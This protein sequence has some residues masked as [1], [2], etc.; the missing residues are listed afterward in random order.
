MAFLVPI[1]SAIAGAA[2]SAGLPISAGLAMAGAAA[3]V[4]F[5]A[6]AAF[7]YVLD[8]IMED[9]AVDTMSGRTLTRKD[10]TASRKIVYGTVRTGGTIVY[11]A[12]SSANNKY[13]HNVVVFSEGE[14]DEISE[15][16]FDDVK[17]MGLVSGQVR[18]YNKYSS[19]ADGSASAVG[20][21]VYILLADGTEQQAL[22][23]ISTSQWTADHDL[24]GI[25]HAYIRLEYSDEIYTN[26]FPKITAVIKGKKQYDPRQD[27]TATAYSGS[28][29]QRIDNEATWQYTN[30]SAVCLLNYMLDERIGLGESLDAF[31]AT[32]LKASMD[33]CDVDI[34]LSGGG[35]QKKY[36]CDGI[37]DSKNSHKANIQNILT[38]MNGQ[39]L[40]SSG[41]YH[42]KSYKYET[43]HA[44]VV[45]EDMILGNI[46]I[47]TKASRR[48]LY[49]RVKG[50]F[51]AEEEN[52]V[53]TEYPTQI[54]Y[55][56]GTTTKQFEID[57][58]ETLYHEYN[59]P[60]TTN[61]VRAQRLARLTMLRSRMQN[62]IKF[63][64]NAKGLLY[65]VGDNI[66]ITNSTLGITEKVY[67]IQRLNVRPDAQSGLTVDIEAKENV[68]DYY[69]WSTTDELT[70][71]SGQTVSLFAGNVSAPTNLVLEPYVENGKSK[72]RATW[73]AS[74][75]QGD[76]IY[77]VYYRKNTTG[78]TPI[79]QPYTY[80]NYIII[81]VDESLFYLGT[82]VTP[83]LQ[84]VVQAMRQATGVVSDSLI[85]TVNASKVDKSNPNNIVRGT[86][87]N[88][89]I[90][91]VTV[92]AQEAGIPL[93]AGVEL[94]Y[95]QVN[96]NDEEIDSIDFVFEETELSVI[97]SRVTKQ[98][99][100]ETFSESIL[101]GT[102]S[103]TNNW[104]LT[105][106]G[107]FE[108]S[109]GK[110]NYDC[111]GDLSFA[112]QN[113]S[114]LTVGKIYDLSFNLSNISFNLTNHILFRIHDKA[115]LDVIYE[116]E[117][118]AG[119]VD[120]NG[121][122]TDTITATTDDVYFIF[123]SGANID[124][125]DTVSIDNLSFTRQDERAEHEVLISLP[126]SVTEDVTFAYD[127]VTTSNST[128]ILDSGGGAIP[129][130]SIAF[131]YFA[132]PT[133]NKLINGRKSVVIR[134]TRIPEGFSQYQG[135]IT[136]SWTESLTLGGTTTNIAR[137]AQVAVNLAVRVEA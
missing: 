95:I 13:L 28:G 81:D 39:L 64:T 19:N 15:I 123:N 44:Q 17:A 86:I 96:S 103:N 22:T 18:Y 32:S 75:S 122:F 84:I 30:N 61:N 124:T 74:E 126:E 65:T 50:K 130:V 77:K 48:S 132:S 12:N 111:T 60:M 4:G 3:V 120:S 136:A 35:T 116:K 134:L 6:K 100:A 89:T 37:I 97:H 88:P 14:V 108:I 87:Q 80:D 101:N 98:A 52:Y 112:Y 106:D 16:Y 57:D 99:V 11:Q 8:S 27:S 117:L 20:N 113:V 131:A 135:N 7:D 102:F 83:N 43:P 125:G 69:N 133:A 34:N 121:D 29:S 49:N 73:T 47:A 70:F 137:T 38:S 5:A 119:L 105:T 109:G 53:M 79:H 82:N 107:D 129:N 51:V 110:L 40:Y 41:K 2:F 23:S 78:Y 91:E 55:T 54:Y 62:S 94:T 59:L 85:G 24:S 76:I 10:S 25:A 66:K 90:E 21:K 104:V 33:D 92:L 93:S 46:D 114:G 1:A 127:T 36:T 42:V 128:G 56:A 118:K 45:T 67:Q 26:G 71:T 58:G 68:E 63:T 31:D 72:I 9:I 115:T